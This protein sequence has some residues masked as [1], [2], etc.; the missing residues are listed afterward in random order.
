MMR[1]SR[2][3][4][5]VIVGLLLIAGLLHPAV[6]LAAQV[7]TSGLSGVV[8]DPQAGVVSGAAIS[9]L[10]VGTGQQRTATTDAKGE[11][12]IPDL[13]AGTYTIQL[14]AA[15][16]KK[17]L[18]SNIVLQV[19]TPVVLDFNLTVGA[20]S[21]TVTVQGS[22]SS[23]AT[24]SPELATVVDQKQ[25]RDIPLN[26]RNF[27]QLIQLAPGVQ[28]VTSTGKSAFIG[29]NDTYSISGSRNEGQA[30]LLDGTDIQ[31]YWQHGSGAGTVGTSLGVEAIDQF[32]T[33]VGVYGAQFG[34]NG[35]A[36]NA[37]TRSG[38]NSFHGS[39]YDYL[40]NDVF[41][42]RNF[43]DVPA[44]AK[45][46]F[47]RNQFGG[48]LGG[49]IV[50][51]KVLFFINYEGLRQML[52]ETQGAVVLDANAHAGYLPCSDSPF[53]PC[54]TTGTYAGLTYVGVSPA[55]QPLLNILPVPTTS[56]GGLGQIYTVGR[57]PANENYVN[58]RVD[59]TLTP[60]TSLFARYVRDYANL[61]DPY[62]TTTVPGFPQLSNNG[63]QYLTVEARR[64][65]S[66]RLIY[67]TRFSYVRLA[68]NATSPNNQP[69]LNF[70][71][72]DIEGL[73]DIPGGSQVGVGVVGNDVQNQNRYTLAEEVYYSRGHHSLRAGVSAAFVQ[74]KSLLDF[75]AGGFY[76][77]SGLAQ[78]LQASP[79]LFQ[80]PVLDSSGN[81]ERNGTRNF[82][83]FDYT[84][85]LQDDWKL[86]NRLTVN[87]GLRYAP[88]T[89]PTS[90]DNN[91][92]AIL[93]P[94]AGDG[95]FTH[96]PAAFARNPEL[97]NIDPRLGLAWDVFGDHRTAVHAAFGI[98]HE[99]YTARSYGPAYNLSAPYNL[100][101]QIY[102]PGTPLPPIVY[103][104]PFEGYP[105]GGAGQPSISNAL[106]YQTSITPYIIQTSLG[107][108][109]QIAPNTVLNVSYVLSKGVHLAVQ[110]NLNPPVRKVSSTG[111]DTF[112]SSQNTL[113]PN[114]STLVYVVPG[115]TSNYNGLQAYI[116]HSLSHS[117]QAQLNYTWSRCMDDA[118]SAFVVES[119]NGTYDQTD[120]YNVHVDY[121]RCAF[122]IR[123]TF[124][125]N[126]MYL[127]PF[128]GNRF[129]EG[130]SLSGV[131]FANT[132]QPFSV[133][134]SYDQAN[135]GD[136]QGYSRPN[137][138]GDPTKGGTVTANP[139]CAAPATVRTISNWYNPCAFQLQA[140]GTLGNERRDTNNAP[141]FT[142]VDI[143]LLKDTR[144]T[145]Q[146]N[147]Q[148]R[149]ETFNIFNHPNF[150]MPNLVGFADSSGVP[151][152]AAGQIDS[153]VN[154]SRQIQFALKLRF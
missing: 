54:L 88:E 17:V 103:G 116:R 72:G 65:A 71:P 142:D 51:N 150:G 78:F 138:V 140:A 110:R 125:G 135:L 27:E 59:Y 107:V 31:G 16:F 147:A 6:P 2:H 67:L 58:A 131:V 52:N 117:V 86:T 153:T 130:W 98:Y 43:F 49:P 13:A 7:G 104:H 34:G 4:H 127:L 143:S 25:V 40:R 20:A 89:N 101:T 126:V 93:T 70:Y 29:R 12:T 105:N 68:G 74:T 21:E 8:T 115:A 111:T 113:N 102:I 5:A 136:A 119:Y 97:K 57:Q 26:G 146:I 18:K 112:A 121:G 75:Q 95:T 123:N 44:L 55:I 77:F 82:R 35:S 64:L 122:D 94:P 46:G 137:E 41:D 39:I 80:G 19:G 91:L 50:K 85:Y 120:P 132:G 73:V 92:E 3:H 66:E 14:S 151:N 48:T 42:A 79:F 53:T 134:D 61:T 145:D 23:V 87:A 129:T 56:S 22:D 32:Q 15:G 11:Y 114:Y 76:V 100:G 84:A 47:R 37:V 148:F 109:R 9:A 33:L 106:S 99:S 128:E 149:V 36:I 90:P 10:N 38:T 30:I 108:E 45:P 69:A 1:L 124:T 139:S 24:T 28:P 118:S 154:S 62:A 96:V 81:P 152:S 60:K 63:N 144:I 141:R 133:Y 83:E